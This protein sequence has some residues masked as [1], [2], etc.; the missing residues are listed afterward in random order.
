[1][2]GESKG[3]NR[4]IA[5]LLNAAGLDLDAAQRLLVDPPNVLAV[6]TCSKPPRRSSAP[7]D[8]TADCS[9]PGITIS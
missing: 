8:F 5:K 7:Y 3:T 6:S 9:T 4:P 2:G 1:M